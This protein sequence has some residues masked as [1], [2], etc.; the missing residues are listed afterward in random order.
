MSTQE[1]SID[2][3]MERYPAS[4]EYL[5]FLLQDVQK[6]FGYIS[7]DYMQLICDR[8]GVP[9]SQAY[10]VTTF[11]QSFRLE[12]Q[13]EHEIKVCLGTACHLKGAS[14]IMDELKRRLGVDPEET[15][16]DLKF[17]YSSVNCVGACALAPVVVMDEE[18]FPGITAKKLEKQLKVLSEE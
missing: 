4:S 17:T 1:T 5:I 2:E 15:T 3:I 13:G 10:S 8:T 11:Y 12:P 9:V 18:Y 14:R 7:P 6:S 16:P